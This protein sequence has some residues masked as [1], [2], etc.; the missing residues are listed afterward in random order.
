MKKL[1]LAG[2]FFLFTASDHNGIS[3]HNVQYVYAKF[4]NMDYVVIVTAGYQ[5]NSTAVINLTKDELEV[6]K[7]KNTK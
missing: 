6:Q 1:F 3:T 7:L 4:R 5:C 2:S